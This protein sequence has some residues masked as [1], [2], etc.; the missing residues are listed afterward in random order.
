MK[1]GPLGVSHRGCFG[2]VK[3]G[4]GAGSM[5]I[6]KAIALCLFSISFSTA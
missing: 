1:S 5:H 6:I 3:D 2:A 4:V